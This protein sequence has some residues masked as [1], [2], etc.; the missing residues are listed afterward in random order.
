MLTDT[1]ADVG[2]SIVTET[3]AWWLEVDC[4]LDTGQITA[5]QV[6]GTTQEVR[7]NRGNRGKDDLGELA[8]GLG[9]IGR[10][11]DGKALLP[12]LRELAGDTASE[13]SV[14]LRILLGVCRKESV[15]LLLKLST[16]EGGS[17]VSVVGLLRDVEGLIGGEANL[18]FQSGDVI[19]LKG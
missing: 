14:F 7:E 5:S 18:R 15:P 11:V 12:A 9:S 13:F 3:S 8:R 19:R 6:G 2:T 10:L 16:L 17:V 4:I 1:I